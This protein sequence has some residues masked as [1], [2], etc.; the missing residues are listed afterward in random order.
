MLPFPEGVTVATRIKC[1]L[2]TVYSI[3]GKRGRVQIFLNPAQTNG[4]QRFAREWKP[5]KEW[6]R[7]SPLGLQAKDMGQSFR[8]NHRKED[9][10]PSITKC[11]CNLVPR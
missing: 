2:Y 4:P 8:Y 10:F 3:E 11:L 9:L 7:E 1:Y 5:K 6:V